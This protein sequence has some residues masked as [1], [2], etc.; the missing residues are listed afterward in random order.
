LLYINPSLTV[1]NK[2]SSLDTEKSSFFVN[3]YLRMFSYV[4]YNIHVR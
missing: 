3:F 4:W 2:K 1:A